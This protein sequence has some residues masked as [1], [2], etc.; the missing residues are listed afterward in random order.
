MFCLPFY[1]NDATDP[2]KSD[3]N[4]NEFLFFLPGWRLWAAAAAGWAWLAW[5]GWAGWALLALLGWLGWLAG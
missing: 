4:Y 3:S 5:L 1:S 2:N